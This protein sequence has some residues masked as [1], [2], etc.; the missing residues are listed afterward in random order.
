MS[1][2]SARSGADVFEDRDVLLDEHIPTELVAR[3]EQVD[4]YLDALMPVFDGFA[5]DHVFLYGANGSGKTAA[6]RFM[7]RELE[8][9]VDPEKVDLSTQWLRCNGVGT[10]YLLAI[11][12]ANR[13]LPSDEQLNRGHAEDVVYDRL[14]DALERVGGTILIV[15]DEI[16]RIEDLDTFLYEI[17]RARSAGGRL[18]DAKVGVIGIS[19]DSHFYESLSSDVRSSLNSKTIDFPAYDAEQLESIL[20]YRVGVAFKPDVVAD[21]VPQLCA[22]HGAKFSGDARFALD[23]LREAGDQAKM[24][25]DGTV[26]TEHVEQA[27][28]VVLEDRV[29]KLLENLNEE[30]KRV[31]YALVVLVARDDETEP[32]TKRVYKVYREIANRAGRKPVVSVQVNE[33]LSQLDQCGL[34]Q[35]V[36]NKGAGG[37]YNQHRLRYE[38]GDVV[39]ALEDHIIENDVV[40][41]QVLPLLDPDALEQGVEA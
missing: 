21:G 20:E 23:L 27:K 15:L 8:D 35:V 28:D 41:E 12:L 37:R 4:Q 30:A 16:D 31:V 2:F 17:T 9:D 11:K 13:L 34:T 36:E 29:T 14:F 39:N 3:E 40:F 33:Y 6:T 22:A 26:T 18:E 1:L 5:P 25:K 10:D 19:K 38:I 24:T 32:R 7:L